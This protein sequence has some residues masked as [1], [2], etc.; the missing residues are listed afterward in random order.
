NPEI[1]SGNFWFDIGSKNTYQID[2]DADSVDLFPL[3]DPIYYPDEF[4]SWKTSY[5]LLVGFLVILLLSQSIRSI[6]RKK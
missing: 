1:K 5:P 4:Y 3:K 6:K 2:G